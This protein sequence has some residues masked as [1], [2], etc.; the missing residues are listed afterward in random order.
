M[1]KN[2]LIS[3]ALLLA[4]ALGSLPARATDGAADPPPDAR[5]Q[6]TRLK[7]ARLYNTT[8][9][10]VRWVQEGGLPMDAN[11][12]MTGAAA[13]TYRMGEHCVV[14]GEI[15][16]RT[17]ADGR[18]YGTRFELRLP[19]D[20]NQR[21]LFQGGG[22]TNGF[23]ADAVGR[24]PVRGATATPALLRGYAVVSTDTGHQ[25]RDTHFGRDQQARLDYAYA[26]IG[27]VTATAR[28]LVDLMYR[29]MPRQT[30]FMG[31]SNGG[32][33]AM[34]AAMRYPLDFDGVIAGNPGF[35]LSRAALAQSWDSQQLLK[36]APADAEGQ[37]ILAN[38]LTPRDMDAVV[39]GVLARCD[40]LDGLKDGLVNAWERCDFRPEM[41]EGAIGAGKVALLKAI[42]EGAHT[43]QGEAVYSSWP[44]DA[45]LNAGNW[46]DWK[47]GHSQTA[48][49]DARNITLGAHSL[50][51]YF[52]TPYQEDFDTFRVDFD[53]DVARTV[54][55]G[56]INDAVSTDLG[57][58]KAR[59]GRMIVF[60]G[61][62]DPVFSAHDLR[63]WFRRLQHDTPGTDSFARLF[64][65]PGMTHCGGGRALDDF[66]PLTALEQ[67][68]DTGEA[69]ERI[70]AQGKAFAGR[71]QPL[72]PY[73]LEAT[74]QQGDENAAES[75]ACQPAPATPS[76]TAAAPGTTPASGPAVRAAPAATVETASAGP[77]APTASPATSSTS[78]AAGH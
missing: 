67:W 61:V 60:Q 12:A 54:Q 53:R 5:A 48:E 47:L 41:V 36:A 77:G 26:A 51:H 9:D 55:I 4:C 70:V 16:S 28:Q 58:F 35:R 17:G 1:M 71:T 40:A 74:Y 8:I 50:P 63:D 13:H 57:T 27:K 10:Q 21:L 2:T 19:A 75:F 11:S 31:C 43:R 69:P 39:E 33:E 32:R 15:E 37:K 45:G 76:G 46:R 44:Y 24:I 73:P 20:W 66:D 25:G 49:P 59:G 64:M 14:R 78:A 6:C 65:V 62:S 3:P 18:H 68:H 7:E 30:F 38:A 22:G 52:M 34:M 29:T 56:A 23:V 72:C 42:F